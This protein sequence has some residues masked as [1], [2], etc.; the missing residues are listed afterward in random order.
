MSQD[1]ANDATG[2]PGECPGHQWVMTHVD[3]SRDGGFIYD[4]CKWCGTQAVTRP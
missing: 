2:V 1:D 3:L 4:E